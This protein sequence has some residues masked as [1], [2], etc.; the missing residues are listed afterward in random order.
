MD[1]FAKH[2]FIAVEC[3]SGTSPNDLDDFKVMLDMLCK[4]YNM[5]WCCSVWKGDIMA[6]L[7]QRYKLDEYQV[8]EEGEKKNG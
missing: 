7:K 5:K 3:T 4:R 2:W 1:K 8:L 6:K